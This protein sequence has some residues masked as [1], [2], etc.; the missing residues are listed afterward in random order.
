MAM[1]IRNTNYSADSSAC[2]TSKNAELPQWNLKERFG[3]DARSR[4]LLN[5]EMQG[6]IMHGTNETKPAMLILY[7]CQVPMQNRKTSNSYS[8]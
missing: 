4:L 2:N 3:N 1:T 8:T 7:K 5:P 6:I